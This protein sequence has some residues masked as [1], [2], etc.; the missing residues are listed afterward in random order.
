[1]PALAAARFRA[2]LP[3]FDAGHYGAPRAGDEIGD[4]AWPAKVGTRLITTGMSAITKRSL[5][6]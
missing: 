1:M 3:R 2:S 5:F 6:T 4:I